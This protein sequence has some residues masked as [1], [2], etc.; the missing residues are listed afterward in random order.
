MFKRFQGLQSFMFVHTCFPPFCY[1]CSLF[2]VSSAPLF[3]C[4]EFSALWQSPF[5]ENAPLLCRCRFPHLKFD[6]IR[7]YRKMERWDKHKVRQEELVLWSPNNF[8]RSSSSHKLFPFGLC[9]KSI[10]AF[11]NFIGKVFIQIF[12]K[13]YG[14]YASHCWME[15]PENFKRTLSKFY[16]A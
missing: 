2:I 13:N 6:F 9:T 5:S 8:S 12:K 1:S 14:S 15:T 10:F 11:W 7:L 3:I 16:F 4:T